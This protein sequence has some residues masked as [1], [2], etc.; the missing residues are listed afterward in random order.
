MGRSVTGAGDGR[1]VT[2]KLAATTGPISQVT[3]TL[4]APAAAIPNQVPYGG[5][6]APVWGSSLTCWGVDLNLAGHCD[7]LIKWSD[8]KTTTLR[9]NPCIVSVGS[10]GRLA[11]RA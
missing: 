6:G 8:G 4:R 2:G 3:M 5:T 9:G 11:P 7:G 1:T 10:F